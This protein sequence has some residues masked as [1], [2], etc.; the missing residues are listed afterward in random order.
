MLSVDDD[1]C[2]GAINSTFNQVLQTAPA[3]GCR[4]LVVF[5]TTANHK[6]A[7]QTIATTPTVAIQQPRLK[8]NTTIQIIWNYLTLLCIFVCDFGEWTLQF[9]FL[10][11]L[12]KWRGRLNVANIEPW[13]YIQVVA[14]FGG[15]WTWEMWAFG[16]QYH[17]KTDRVIIYPKKHDM[18]SE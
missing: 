13:S 14:P 9:V 6:S 10:F 3:N 5:C 18:K 7:A 12:L 17:S 4:S 2:G 16:W 8:K 11:S 1:A 15:D